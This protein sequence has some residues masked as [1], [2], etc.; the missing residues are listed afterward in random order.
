MNP[1]K[2]IILLVVLVGL[3]FLPA[4]GA[5]SDGFDEEGV[6][7]T[8][9]KISGEP[10]NFQSV[11]ERSEVVMR[12]SGFDRPDAIQAEVTRLQQA[13]A[14]ANGEREFLITVNDSIS[15]YDHERGQFSINLFMP[16]YYVPVQAFGQ[17][18]QLVFAN[19]ESGRA[20]V[21]PKEEARG[22]DAQLNRM[23]R[24]VSNEIRFR[25]IGKGDPAGAVTGARVIRAEMTSARLLDRVGN[26]LFLP[27]IV[28]H[29]VPDAGKGLLSMPV[30]DVAGFRVGVRAKD[31]E[32]TLTRMFG[33]AQR[34]PGRSTDWFAGKLTVNET[35]CVPMFGRPSPKPGAVCISAFV[36][37]D[38]VI[39]SIRVER[40]FS[41]FDAEVFRKALTQKYGPVAAAVSGSNF[42]LGWGPEVDPKLGY[43]QSAPHNALTAHYANNA[44]FLSR[45]G[46]ALPQIRIVL[47]LADAGWA[48]GRK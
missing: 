26:V 48:A 25:V 45:S 35:G 32:A 9:H 8:Y 14:A 43:T 34:S 22:F 24:S 44:D 37:Q 40:V 4:G 17:L 16:G 47:S 28:P 30:A 2:I 18:Y 15:Q 12:A 5:Q 11:A 29:Q 38:D 33:P 10:L 13:L 21:M 39:R 20:I 36:D 19:A 27:K 41:Y 6:A 7:L 1:M 42:A 31:L 3:L 46:N 23:G